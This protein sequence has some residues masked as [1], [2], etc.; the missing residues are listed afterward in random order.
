[1]VYEVFEKPKNTYFAT[2]NR[3]DQKIR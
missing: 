2:Q 1:V 3:D